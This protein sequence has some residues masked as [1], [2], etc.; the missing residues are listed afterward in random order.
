MEGF[1]EL[2]TPALISSG[3]RLATP[4]IL[5]ALG[6]ALCNRAGVLNLALE[7][8]MLLGAFL[9]IVV[10]FYAGSTYVGIGVAVLAGGMLGLL[11]AFLYLRY[12]VN[13]IIL[14]LAIN[15]LILEITVY[16]MRVL[17]GNV[18]SWSDP[19]IERLQGINIPIIQDI[20]FLGE[21]LSGHNFIVY[22][23]WFDHRRDALCPGR[24][25]S[26]R[27]PPDAVYQKY[28]QRPRLGGR[29]RRYLRL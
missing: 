26:F 5:A 29:G 3:I 13:L 17:F 6:G 22:F 16:F 25:F 10:A 12:E 2:M 14:A 18:G 19:S 8:K 15:M 1:T 4:I 28:E 9:G 21:V 24:R 20:P 7:G 23:S 11:F 27:R